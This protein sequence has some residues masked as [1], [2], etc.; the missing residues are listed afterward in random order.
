MC[1]FTTDTLCQT[2][3]GLAYWRCLNL[4]IKPHI[5]LLLVSFP[6]TCSVWGFEDLKVLVFGIDRFGDG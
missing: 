3:K 2:Q 5:L 4:C 6:L 1:L